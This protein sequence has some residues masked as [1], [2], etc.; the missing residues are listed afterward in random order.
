MSLTSFFTIVCFEI[1]VLVC[2]FISCSVFKDHLHLS[3]AHLYYQILFTSSNVFL[4]FFIFF[5]VYAFILVLKENWHSA[6]LINQYV[7]RLYT[8]KIH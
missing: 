3:S 2:I 8:H 1:D 4:I 7:L 6:S 5:T